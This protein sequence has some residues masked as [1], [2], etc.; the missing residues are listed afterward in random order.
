[1]GLGIIFMGMS[2]MGFKT[3]LFRKPGSFISSR[4]CACA[5][6]RAEALRRRFGARVALKTRGAIMPRMNR[7]ALALAFLFASSCPSATQTLTCEPSS[8]TLS[9]CWGDHGRT[10]I[11]EERSGDCVHGHDDRGRSWTTWDHNGRTYTRP[12]R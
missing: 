3:R 10:V 12:T 6:S 1:M 8:P 5:L 4:H 9:H 2:K 7:A 11:T